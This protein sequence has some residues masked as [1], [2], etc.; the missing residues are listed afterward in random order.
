VSAALKED[1]NKKP[2][3]VALSTQKNTQ[4]ARDF[5]LRELMA[6]AEPLNDGAVFRS[7]ASVRTV[8]VSSSSSSSSAPKVP[9]LLPLSYTHSALFR[10]YKLS[11]PLPVSRSTFC[12]ECLAA[13]IANLI[14]LRRNVGRMPKCPFCLDFHHLRLMFAA[15]HDDEALRLLH[16]Q[17]EGHCAFIRAM[18]SAIAALPQQQ[19]MLTDRPTALSSPYAHDGELRKSLARSSPLVH[20]VQGFLFG[21]RTLRL[22]VC[23]KCHPMGANWT[24]HTLAMLLLTPGIIPVRFLFLLF[25]LFIYFFFFFLLR[26]TSDRCPSLTH[27]QS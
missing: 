19:T 4:E 8:A 17:H 21:G 11:V 24:L 9:L 20:T 15:L 10:A 23:T 5:I 18:R 3:A 25:I 1:R 7:A 13:M 27:A 12:A 26:D 2:T 14:R 16:R 6:I 22:Y